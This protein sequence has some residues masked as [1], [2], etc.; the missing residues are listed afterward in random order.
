MLPSNI[1][2]MAALKG[3]DVIAVT[4]HNSC[5][6]CPAVMKLAEAY[7]LIAIPGMEICTAEEVHVVCLFPTLQ[8]ALEFDKH[9]HS[10]L[11]QLENNEAIFGK[12]QIV[13]EDD[14]IIGTEPYLLINA[15][16]ICFDDLF[17]VVSKY[18]GIMIPAHIEKSTNSMLS[19]LGMVPPDS[20]FKCSE[21]K[22]IGYR[23]DILVKNPYLNKCKIITNSD[24]HYL[25]HIN[26]PVNFIDAKSK[27]IKDVLESLESIF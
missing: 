12:Q 8:N 21:I 15:C 9:V 2:G 11:P 6:N 27:S 3:L 23:E 10:V 1:V 24:A 5:K 17:E 4:D 18:N 26:E 14:E 25:E 20:K 22:H 19:N 7:G 13:N 16:N